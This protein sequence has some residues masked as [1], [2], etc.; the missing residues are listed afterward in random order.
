MSKLWQ[1]VRRVSLRPPWILLILGYTAVFI[2]FSLWAFGVIG[3]PDSPWEVE[4]RSA[5]IIPLIPDAVERYN[6]QW[7]GATNI[8]ECQD[9]LT[10]S[11][12]L[13]WV[14]EEGI[15]SVP[16]FCFGEVTIR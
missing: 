3:T 16:V 7:P 9:L 4:V 2:F 10:K 5:I 8:P 12:Y 1:Q 11:N 6:L 14:A 13:R 15:K